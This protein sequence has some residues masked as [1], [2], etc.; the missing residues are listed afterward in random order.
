MGKC[1]LGIALLALIATLSAGAGAQ[2]PD[3]KAKAKEA[4]TDADKAGPDYLLQ[5][6]FEGTF[7]GRKAGAQ[8]VALGDGKFDV[9]LLPGGLP[10]AGWDGKT[11]VKASAER[12]TNPGLSVVVAR[13]KGKDWSGDCL[14]STAKPSLYG[15]T[16]RG[17]DFLFNHVV[18]KG[19]T[20]GAK[21]PEGAVVLFDGTSADEWKGGKLVE[22]NLLA[23]GVSSKRAFKD[24]R[25]HLEFRCPFQPYARGQG[26]GNSGVY[27][28]GRHEIQVLDSFGLDG[29]NNECGG[30]YGKAAPSVNLCLPPLSWQTYDI[31]YR[32]ARFDADGKKVSGA[33]LTVLHNGVTVH[34]RLEIPGSGARPD[35]EKPGPINLQNHGNPVYYRNIWVVEAK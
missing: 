25:L 9:Y 16:P 3:A 1:L 32:A 17:E 10:G 11:K 4:F 2:Q 34:D 18:R 12:D 35:E 22:G 21:P 6:E 26:R 15:K 28:Q 14:G 19:P 30:L 5:G 20:L 24:F 27:L 31:E 33:V 13:L 7:A 8:V 23:T 29:K